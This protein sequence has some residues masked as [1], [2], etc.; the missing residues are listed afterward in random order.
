MRRYYDANTWKFLLASPQQAIHRELWG[1]A[2][3]DRGEAAHHAHALVLD[4]LDRLGRLDEYGPGVRRVLDLGCGVG[5]A[6]RYLAQ[7]RD[8]EVVGVTISPAQ[9]RLAQRLTSR[10]APTPG[11]VRFRV[12]DFTALPRETDRGQAAF[13]PACFDLAFAIESFVHADPADAFFAEASRVLRPGGVLVVIDDVRTG[14]PA[15]PRL[16][17][18]LTGWQVASLLSVP[19]IATAADAAGLPLE[20]SRDLS[21]LQRLGRPRD[22]LIHAS[23]PLLRGLRGRSHWAAALVGGDALQS[24]HRAGLLEY[25]L[26]RFVRAGDP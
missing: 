22:R 17:D 20:A 24:C 18:F 14:D 6:G 9:A 7:R 15:D 8:V 23:R 19:E 21:A 2:V 4:E 12:A 13:H 16:D 1:P 10:A 3:D 5:A 26:L 25:R 11:R